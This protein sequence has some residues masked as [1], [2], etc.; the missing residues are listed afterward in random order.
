MNRRNL[1]LRQ[2]RFVLFAALSVI[3]LL[4]PVYIGQG[5]PWQHA[6]AA[7]VIVVVPGAALV[8]LVWR[9]E[10]RQRS[11]SSLLRILRAAFF[12]GAWTAAIVAISYLVHPDA[13]LAFLKKGAI[14]Q[15]IGGLVLYM[16]ISARAQMQNV[17]AALKEQELAATRLELNALQ[18][19][20]NP[21]FL[22]NTLH[23]LTQLAKEDMAATE[24]ALQQFGD[25][26]RYVLQAGRNGYEDVSLEDEL[27]FV[28][29]YLKLE[30]LRF[31]SRLRVE[32]QIEPDCL[33]MGVPPLLL[34]P[35]VENAV[36][37]G[38]A[39]IPEGGVI[40]IA[41]RLQVESMI[42]EVRDTGRGADAKE[43]LT[44]SGVGLGVVRRQIETRFPG[45]GRFEVLT[46]P[47]NGFIARIQLPLFLPKRAG[48]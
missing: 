28:R 13:A 15:L 9:I 48:R 7:A 39:P 25:L 6:I 5:L 3:V 35:L 36:C 26:M 23:A 1:K 32:E 8:T 4:I 40:T 12:S 24:Q 33:E 41:A 16:A 19:Q 43:W 29:N 21:H 37:H 38:I 20:L 31:N 14:W 22:F 2:V 10:S 46:S 18:A 42:V 45:V 17:K 44:T 47:G 27:T 30:Q 34:Q 11:G